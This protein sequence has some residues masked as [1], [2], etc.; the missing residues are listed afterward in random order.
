[1]VEIKHLSVS[2]QDPEKVATALAAMTGGRAQPFLSRNMP[3]AWVCL[4]DAATNHLIEFLPKGY[5][6]HATDYGADFKAV[7][8]AQAYNS[9]HVQLAVKT[10]LRDLQAVADQFGFVHKFRPNRGGPLYDIW[11]EEQF[12]VE[13][14]S[15]EIKTLSA[16]VPIQ[17][18]VS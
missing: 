16:P 5:L 1:M 15:D 13:F 9:T 7:G 17:Q 2:V 8:S 11:F 14:V 18:G 10:P 3:G 12:L 6:M 4:W